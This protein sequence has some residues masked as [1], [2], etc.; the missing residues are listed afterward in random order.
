MYTGLYFGS[1][2]P[3]HIGHMALANYMLSFTEMQEVWFVVSPQNPL[4]EKTGLL[5]D[6]HRLELV[7]QAIGDYPGFRASNI[8]FSMPQPSYTIDTLARLE[9]KY[10]TKKFALI[11]GE[12]NL[13]HFHKWKNHEVIMERYA[14]FVY[15]RLGARRNIYHDHKNV[16][17]VEAPQIEISSSFIRK[18]CAQGLDVKFFMPHQAWEYMDR[19]N[20]YK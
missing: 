17:L 8:E 12:D 14:L 11:M 5:A 2:N 15:P 9:E 10:P 20:F 18:S 7:H 6:H 13:S 4:K 1:F 3:V 19:M 16:H